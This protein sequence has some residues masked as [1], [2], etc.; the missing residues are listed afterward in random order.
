MVVAVRR[1]VG[2]FG[3]SAWCEPSMTH[4]HGPRVGVRILAP[5]CSARSASVVA[6]HTAIAETLSSD[7]AAATNA[8]CTVR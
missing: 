1:W 7:A 5:A 2:R 4:R 3:V 8:G 6:A